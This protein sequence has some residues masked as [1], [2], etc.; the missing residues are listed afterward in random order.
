[1]MYIFY[2]KLNVTSENFLKLI[3]FEK[4]ACVSCFHL[5]PLAKCKHNK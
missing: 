3:L 2:H 4:S 5:L 1:M